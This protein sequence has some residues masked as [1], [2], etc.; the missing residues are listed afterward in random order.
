MK[1]SKCCKTCSAYRNTLRALV[2][3]NKKA[4]HQNRVDH[5]SK[6]NDRW[7]TPSELTEKL[8][9][10]RDELKRANIKI[11]A[12]SLEAVG[13]DGVTVEDETHNDS[14]TIMK[15]NADLVAATYSENSFPRLFWNQ[16]VKAAS[17]HSAKSM[18]WHPVMIRWCL[19]LRHISGKGYNLLRESGC[20][21]LPSPR[22]LRD[23]TYYNNTTIGFSAATD[24]ELLELMRRKGLTEEWQKLVIIIFDEMYI[25][26]GVAYNKHTGRVIGLVDIGDINNHLLRYKLFA[27]CTK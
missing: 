14:V 5:H 2:S 20:L 13:M 25:K 4:N 18:R 8:N 6:M 24:K 16:Q 21:F 17:Q 27:A 3:R 23:Y 26:E 1:T 9:R 10:V 12:L 15:E 19:Y 11:K 22:T 7:R